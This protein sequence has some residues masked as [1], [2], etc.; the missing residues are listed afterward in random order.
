MSGTQEPAAS[1]TAAGSDTG[2]LPN[3]EPGAYYKVQLSR[4]IE[5]P[6]G[7]GTFMRP[8]ETHEWDGA[9]CQQFKDAISGASIKT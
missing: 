4:P 1:N 6:P 9:F 2:N 5:F 8:G 3:F 7:S